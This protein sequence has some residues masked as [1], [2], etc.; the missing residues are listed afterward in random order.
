[1]SWP[2]QND[3]EAGVLGFLPRKA[4]STEV[5]PVQK[6]EKHVAVLKEHLKIYFTSEVEIQCLQLS[7]LVFSHFNPVF[8]HYIPFL[9]S[10][11]GN[12]L[13]VLLYVLSKWYIFLF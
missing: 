5:Q 12:I 1:M 3:S 11:K 4:D 6:T 9:T 10:W 8:S 2:S 7:Q 13:H